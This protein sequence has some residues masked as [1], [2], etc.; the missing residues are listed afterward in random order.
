MK[1]PKIILVKNAPPLT[2]VKLDVARISDIQ[3]I[4]KNTPAIPPNEDK[5]R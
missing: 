2:H 1:K 3:N 4:L 5:P